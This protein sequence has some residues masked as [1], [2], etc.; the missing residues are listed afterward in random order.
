M[1]RL[2][3]ELWSRNRLL[4]AT[5]LANAALLVV[6]LLAALVDDTPI[7]GIN[8][9][10]KPM[11]F[12]ISIAIF[13]GT[14]AWILAYLERSD[15]AVRGISRV[16]AA[17]MF[18]EI[19]L[20]TMQAARGLRSH[21]NYETSLDNAIFQTMGAMIV[22]NTI[23]IGYAAYLFSRRSSKVSGAHL[24]GVRLGLIVFVLGSL[25]GAI[26]AVHDSHGVGVRDGG[27]G[28]P[29][30]NWSTD[31]G[32]LRVAHF[33]GLHALQALPV[34]G[35]WLDR[36]RIAAARRLMRAAAFAWAFVTALL[37]AQALAGRPLVVM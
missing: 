30:V 16:V 4:A 22:V 8:R 1:R 26:M 31:G 25:V 20:I 33:V 21:F 18:G 17:T 5:S 24:T 29:I 35:W 28:L 2:V 36:R 7:L 10:I 14:M 6:L 27:P 15:R 37:L 19:A 34:A 13:T 32:D 3:A 11:K 9:W 12:A 23:A